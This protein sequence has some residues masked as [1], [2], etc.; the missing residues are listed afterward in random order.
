MSADPAPLIILRLPQGLRRFFARPRGVVVPGDFTNLIR[1]T[2]ICVG[3]VVSS[4]CVRGLG[5]ARS[6]IVFDGLTRRGYTKPP[7]AS[8]YR[9]VRVANPRGG[10]ALDA[11]REVCRASREPG[12]AVEV[13]G[14]EDMLTLAALSCAPEGSWVVYGMPGQGA[15]LVRGSW[16]VK[17]D[18]TARLLAL[19]P[20]LAST[21]L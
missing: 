7:D 5:A 17:A 15:V 18:A 12:W 19:K 6:S 14:E 8:G 9:V 2:A 13:V 11:A 16:H 1:G 10:L 4:Y 21:S 20:S 3:D